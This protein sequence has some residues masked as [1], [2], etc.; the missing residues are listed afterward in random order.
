[1]RELLSEG[2]ELA[3]LKQEL[4]D[5]TADLSVLNEKDTRLCQ[6]VRTLTDNLDRIN[7]RMNGPIIDS[8]LV[9][10]VRAEMEAAFHAREMELQESATSIKRDIEQLE[11]I[12]DL[13]ERQLQHDSEALQLAAHNPEGF[14]VICALNQS[15]L[16]LTS[17]VSQAKSLIGIADLNADLCG[18]TL[19]S[20]ACRHSSPPVTGRDAETSRR[21]SLTVNAAKI[22]KELERRYSEAATEWKQRPKDR[23]EF[24]RVFGIEEHKDWQA[25]VRRVEE[26]RGRT[27]GRDYAIEYILEQPDGSSVRFDYVDFVNDIIV[28]RKPQSLEETDQ[29]LI[30]IHKQQSD[31]YEAAY[32]ARFGR[33]PSI[34]YSPYPSTRD[35]FNPS[36]KGE[37][38]KSREIGATE[39]TDMGIINVPLSEIREPDEIDSSSFRKVSETD[40]RRGL[41]LLQDI[42]PEVEKGPGANRDYWAMKDS[43]MGLD[44]EHG[45]QRIYEAFYGTDGIRV[46]QVGESYSVTNGRHR[47]HLAKQLG[48]STL[49]MKVIIGGKRTF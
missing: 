35:L 1:M 31:K 28:D 11:I 24:A 30:D 3:V 22:E 40:M 14:Q 4:G 8:R 19:Q 36:P 15:M 17:I 23:A 45:Y 10:Q 47:I 44:Y 34:Y 26:A 49:P 32:I 9:S 38:A 25:E 41:L 46:E 43:Q 5:I 2:V 21:D 12:V 13:A 48:I 37:S 27:E 16:E 18:S 42:L 7:D 39:W 33:L 20:L 6:E 29:A